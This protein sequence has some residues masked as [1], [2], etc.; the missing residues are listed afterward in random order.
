MAALPLRDE[1]LT[2]VGNH[3]AE[4]VEA[5]YR[6]TARAEIGQQQQR[7]VLAVLAKVV[8]AARDAAAELPVARVAL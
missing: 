1:W 7:S 4:V 6:R 3:P 2:G 5:V 8:G